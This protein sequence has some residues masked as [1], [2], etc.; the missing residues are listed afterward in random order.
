MSA[1]WRVTWPDGTSQE[2]SSA[3]ALLDV[4]RAQSFTPAADTAAIKHLLSD[5][6]WRLCDAAVDPLLD[7][8]AFVRALA[9]AG[10]FGLG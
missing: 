9:A 4:L 3:S 6:A 10:L 2:A 1:R 5:R 8:E 7:D